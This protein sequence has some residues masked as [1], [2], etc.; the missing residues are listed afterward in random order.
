GSYGPPAYRVSSLSWIRSYLAPPQTMAPSAPLP[1]GS[2]STH[3]VAGRGY[4]RR[5]WFHAPGSAAVSM[6]P[7]SAAEGRASPPARGAPGTRPSPPATAARVAALSASRRRGSKLMASGRGRMRLGPA[8]G[9]CCPHPGPPP[10]A[11]EGAPCTPM[12]R[13]RPLRAQST[14]SPACGG[15]PE[16]GSPGARRASCPRPLHDHLAAVV[17]HRDV[18]RRLQ[19]AVVAARAVDE[20]HAQVPP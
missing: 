7:A 16:W 5:R 13:L 15:R 20:A 17:H 8:R 3:W 18:G 14:P 10:H 4:Q 6:A 11:G 2:A 9:R 19:R 12:W 1:S